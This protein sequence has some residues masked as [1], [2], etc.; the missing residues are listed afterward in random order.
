MLLFVICALIVCAAS[1]QKLTFFSPIES[2]AAS[3][4]VALSWALMRT[5]YPMAQLLVYV[6]GPNTTNAETLRRLCALLKHCKLE[7]FSQRDIFAKRPSN[8]YVQVTGPTG[9]DELYSM[10]RDASVAATTE[11][12]SLLQPDCLVRGRISQA[13]LQRCSS[14]TA[15]AACGHKNDVNVLEAHMLAE[16]RRTHSAVPATHFTFTCGVLWKAALGKTVFSQAHADAA[17]QNKCRYDDVCLSL[18]IYS[19]NYTIL[20][21]QHTLDNDMQEYHE[22]SP[23]VHGYKLHYKAGWLNL[24]AGLLPLYDLLKREMGQ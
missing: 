12:V 23:V 3:Y 22:F 11:F 14:E 9:F 6:N 24:P 5:S 16:L 20:Y 19:S 10:Y 7:H 4:K 2:H 15:A 17:K 13:T 1:T 18:S 8:I 21:S